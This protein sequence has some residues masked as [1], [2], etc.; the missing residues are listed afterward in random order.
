MKYVLSTILLMMI[1]IGP[2]FADRIIFNTDDLSDAQVAAIEAS[3]SKAKAEFLLN[4]SNTAILNNP[5]TLLKYVEIGEGI[6]KGLGAAARELGV[7]T[8]EFLTTPAGMLVVIGIA[9]H[10]IGPGIIIAVIG[11]PLLLAITMYTGNRWAKSMRIN[12]YT[13]NDKGKTVPIFKERTDE[14]TWWAIFWINGFTALM[15]V[16]EVSVLLSNI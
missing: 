6:A 8:N 15:M 16:I 7:A 10:I 3:A 11:L 9:W 4:N 5:D 2:A 14:G 1:C 12:S 13:V